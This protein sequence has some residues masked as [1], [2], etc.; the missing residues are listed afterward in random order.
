MTA[1]YSG[2]VA[3]TLKGTSG[4]GALAYGQMACARQFLRGRLTVKIM[5]LPC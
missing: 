2:F 4:V 5:G 1:R 3:G